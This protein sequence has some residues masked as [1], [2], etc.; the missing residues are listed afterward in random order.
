MGTRAF[1]KPVFPANTPHKPRPLRLWVDVPLLLTTFSLVV[2]GLLMVY[3]ASWNYVLRSGE[4]AGYILGRQMIWVA[5]G[6][7]LAG[8]AA[9]FDYH[10]F[11]KLVLPM[12][13]VTLLLLIMVLV[14]EGNPYAPRRTFLQGS[15]Q[16][17]EL[18]KISTIIYLS[19]WLFS[20]H[21][22][23]NDISLG[24]VP[25]LVILGITSGL[26]LF[27][28]DLSAAATIVILGGILFYLAGG[29]FRQIILVVII[30]ALLAGITVTIS[31]TGR[32]RL[33]EY[34]A[35]FWN[36]QE[37]SYHVR[38]SMES[39][40]RGG[41][42][43]VGIGKGVTKFTGLPVPWTDSIFAVIVEETGI[44][45][46]FLVIFLFVVFLWRG[47][48]IAQR[49]P[50]LLGKL[51]AGGLTI[52]ITLEALV[53]IGVMV[54]LFPF[55]G[56]AL[57]LISAGGSSMVASLVAIGIIMGISRSAAAANNTNEGRTFS[58]VVDLRGRDRRRG[59]SR[60]RRPSSASR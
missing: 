51:L 54:H 58:A 17:S 45:G 47:L 28:P 8:I 27:Q 43:G 18:A 11:K 16:P 57:P 21:D 5:T 34:L 25:L 48:A 1:V 60:P 4:N 15:I 6:L 35:G 31:N 30:V 59:I 13:V 50:D 19:V 14:I 56:N 46:G 39:V 26:I 37:A 2:F 24:L 44:A 12:M 36:P 7:L 9:F 10:R 42:F 41:L 40:V 29:E 38:R 22:K 53:N 32:T 33:A 55:A 49:A 52:W 20:K 3:S 23:I